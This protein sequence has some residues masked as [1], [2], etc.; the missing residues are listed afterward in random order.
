M[1]WTDSMSSSKCN[2]QIRCSI[3]IWFLAS[4]PLPSVICALVKSKSILTDLAALNIYLVMKQLTSS[5]RLPPVSFSPAMS[6][7]TNSELSYLNGTTSGMNVCDSVRECPI[8]NTFTL[9]GYFWSK[10]VIFCMR[11]DFSDPSAFRSIFSYFIF[12]TSKLSVPNA[13]DVNIVLF[14]QPVFPSAKMTVLSLKF[15]FLSSKMVFK[16]TTMFFSSNFNLT[17]L[18]LSKSW[19]TSNFF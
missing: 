13:S 3:C 9:S 18:D 4:S 6:M 1:G 2:L 16:T 14:P 11:R 5:M 15:Q 17:K 10:T 19:S 7:K 8:L 12:L